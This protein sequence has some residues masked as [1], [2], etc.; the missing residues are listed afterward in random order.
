MVVLGGNR[1]FYLTNHVRIGRRQS[2]L[3]I[4]MPSDKLR[5]DLLV[6]DNQSYAGIGAGDWPLYV[7][8]APK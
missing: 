6:L 3:F 5:R 7:E 8:A 1:D 4:E 2:K